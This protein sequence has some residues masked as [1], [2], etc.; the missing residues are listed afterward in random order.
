MDSYLIVAVCIGLLSL[1]TG[2]SSAYTCDE[3][4]KPKIAVAFFFALIII[5]RFAMHVALFIDLGG[6]AV[7]V[8]VCFL[9]IRCVLVFRRY[10]AFFVRHIREPERGDYVFILTTGWFDVF[11]TYFF[12]IGTDDDTT[13]RFDANDRYAVILAITGPLQKATVEDKLMSW[14]AMQLLGIHILEIIVGWAVVLGSEADAL[15]ADV[16]WWYALVWGGVP[17][18]CAMVVYCGLPS[19]IRKKPSDGGNTGLTAAICCGA[20]VAGTAVVQP[21]GTAGAPQ[22]LEA[23]G[24]CP[25]F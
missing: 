3:K 18:A 19:I 10:Y 22:D 23:P 8:M 12:P 6:S 20:A 21:E 15:H 17:L 25:C 24:L 5:A 14:P 13:G 4:F 16:G 7:A 9:L 11:L 2:I 1:S